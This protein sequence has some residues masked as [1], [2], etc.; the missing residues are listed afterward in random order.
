M[1]LKQII[2]QELNED[3]DPALLK[4]LQQLMT[5]EDQQTKAAAQAKPV[6]D[7][8]TKLLLQLK[9]QIAAAS[10][11]A[12]KPAAAPATTP[13][14]NGASGAAPATAAGAAPAAATAQ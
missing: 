6:D 4:N 12:V 2:D 3:M 10:K 14:A 1:T 11:P 13:A 9:Q 7:T 5:I 8:K